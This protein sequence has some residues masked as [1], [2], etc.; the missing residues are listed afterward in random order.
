[1]TSYDVFLSYGSGDKPLVRELAARLKAV[2]FSVYL[3]V[4][5]LADKDV[6][7]IELEQALAA[8][9]SFVL[10]VGPCGLETGPTSS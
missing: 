1:M 9:L 2:G 6:W 10:C 7:R 3:D 4:D 5:E 8:S